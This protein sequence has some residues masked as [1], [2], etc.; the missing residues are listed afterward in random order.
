ME[1]ID[2]KEFVD[3]HTDA[4]QRVSL[5]KTIFDFHTVRVNWK[6][7]SRIQLLDLYHRLN[8]VENIKKRWGI[9]VDWTKISK[10]E[11]QKIQENGH[12]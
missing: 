1:P 8:L 4:A 5:A 6:K 10:E 2:V 11:L 7:H 12:E 3:I 9:D